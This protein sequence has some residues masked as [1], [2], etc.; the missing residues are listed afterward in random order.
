MELY[1]DLHSQPCR[2][3]YLL[4]K[5]TGIPFTFRLVDLSAG[6][7]EHIASFTVF[8]FLRGLCFIHVDSLFNLTH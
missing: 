8:F 7:A 1:L 2:S 3:V 5:R 4:A 6:Q